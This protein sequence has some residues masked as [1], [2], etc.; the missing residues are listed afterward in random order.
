MVGCVGN[1]SGTYWVIVIRPQLSRTATSV[2][3]Y[4]SNRSSLSVL[5]RPMHTIISL[6]VDLNGCAETLQCECK[7]NVR[8]LSQMPRAWAGMKTRVFQHFCERKVGEKIREYLRSLCPS[9]LAMI[10]L[11]TLR[12]WCN[13]WR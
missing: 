5:D 10:Q 13:C 3:G 4:T 1:L 7:Q 8:L 6:S 2:E 11:D 9:R 12:S